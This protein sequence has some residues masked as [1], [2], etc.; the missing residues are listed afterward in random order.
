MTKIFE[1]KIKFLIKIKFF[2]KFFKF[3]KF[4]MKFFKFRPVGE[5]LWNTLEVSRQFWSRPPVLNW[6]QNAMP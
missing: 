2:M 1:I 5:N 6:T 4:F 3:F